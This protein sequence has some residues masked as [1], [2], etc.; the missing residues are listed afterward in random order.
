[1][2]KTIPLRQQGMEPQIQRTDES[3]EFYT[4]ERCHILELSNTDSDTGLSIARVRVEPGM[5]TAWHSI[6]DTA[7]RYIILSGIG[8]VEVEGMEAKDV[9]QN[10][11]VIIP[12]SAKQ[13]ITNTSDTDL[14]FL[15]VCTPRFEQARYQHLE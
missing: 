6:I 4:E 11:V 8:R 12:A 9:Q 13:R 10:D 3:K 15:A 2:L 5:T 14:I 7:E 1:M